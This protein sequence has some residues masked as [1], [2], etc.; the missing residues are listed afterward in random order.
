MTQL[1]TVEA[2][3]GLSPTPPLIISDAS[4]PNLHGFWVSER[5]VDLHRQ[6]R[7]GKRSS[8]STVDALS[9]TSIHSASQIDEA[10]QATR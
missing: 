8:G 6:S 10:L 2:R 7:S 5:D 1:A 9:Q 4:S 3:V